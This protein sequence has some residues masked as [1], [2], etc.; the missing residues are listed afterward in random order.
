[1][2][3]HVKAWLLHSLTQG[4]LASWWTLDMKLTKPIL[5]PRQISGTFKANLRQI[6]DKSWTNVGQKLGKS[7]THLRQMLGKSQENLKHI[8]G[9]YWANLGRILGWANLS[10]ISVISRG[11]LREIPGKS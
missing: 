11:T 9:K 2:C 1:M 4:T 6:S 7:L 5:R 8:S 3:E 10:Q